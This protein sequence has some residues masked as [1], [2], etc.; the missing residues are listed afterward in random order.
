MVIYKKTVYFM[1]NV[2]HDLILFRY[3]IKLESGYKLL[4]QIP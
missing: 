1:E 4:K 3:Q 2:Q